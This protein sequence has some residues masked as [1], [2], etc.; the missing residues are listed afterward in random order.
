MKCQSGIM[1]V[2]GSDFALWR[3]KKN[4]SWNVRGRE[5][6]RPCFSCH[7]NLALEKT[8]KWTMVPGAMENST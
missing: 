2:F 6:R 4:H 8:G 1:I 3:T 5:E 7:L